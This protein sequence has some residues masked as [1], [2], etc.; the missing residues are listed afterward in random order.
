MSVC[1]PHCCCDGSIIWYILE[2]AW[3]LE[4]LNPAATPLTDQSHTHHLGTS[5]LLPSLGQT[6]LCLLRSLCLAL[7][8]AAIPFV[9]ETGTLLLHHLYLQYRV[10]FTDSTEK[11]KKKEGRDPLSSP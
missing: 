11:K 3:V 2:S 7:A 10:H 1:P 4:T 6:L 5:W 8:K 9:T